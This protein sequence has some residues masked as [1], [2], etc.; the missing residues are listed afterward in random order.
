MRSAAL[1]LF[2]GCLA[3][4]AA[5]YW[6]GPSEGES[7]R[8]PGAPHVHVAESSSE[9]P[10]G[11]SEASASGSARTRLEAALAG[12]DPFVSA[13]RVLAWIESAAPGEFAELAAD[14]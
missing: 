6:L 14:P 1:C 7:Q 13:P 8:A 2:T 5:R 4:A 11:S 10:P 9:T 12:D 3:F